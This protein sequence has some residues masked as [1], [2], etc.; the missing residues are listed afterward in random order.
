MPANSV[1]HLAGFHATRVAV[2]I[3]PLERYRYIH[4]AVHGTTDADIPQLSSL[5]LSA[6]N[7]NGQ[8]IVDR[9]W[10][11]DLLTRSFGAQTIVLSACDTALG[12]RVAGEGLVGLRY[13]ALA[14]GAQSVVASLWAVPDQVTAKLMDEFYGQLIERNQ[15]ADAALAIAMRRIIASGL[16]DPV[17]WSAFTVTISTLGN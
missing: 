3:A 7:Q 15:S 16:D 17:L 4:F 11:G 10:A 9:V 13:V 2:L 14:R 12:R 5:V 6:F 1:D 8:R